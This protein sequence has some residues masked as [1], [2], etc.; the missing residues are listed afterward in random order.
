MGVRLADRKNLVLGQGVLIE[1][2]AVLIGDRKIRIGDGSWVGSYCNFRPVDYSINIGKH[3]LIGQ[4]VSIISDSHRYEDIA[5]DI[6]EQ[7][8]YGADINIEDNVWIGCNSVILHGVRIATG[9][10]V[11][12]GSVVTRSVPAHCVVGGNPARII[13]RYSARRAAWVRYSWFNRLLFRAGL[14]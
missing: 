11:A 8:T 13:K 6:Q 2:T 10:V 5:L 9:S 4:L 3:V 7:G 1:P 14:F 12:A